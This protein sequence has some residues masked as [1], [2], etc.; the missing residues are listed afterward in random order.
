MSE[1]KFTRGPWQAWWRNGG[2]GIN[3]GSTQIAICA[4]ATDANQIT[5]EQVKA[6]AALMALAPEMH[7]TILE[8]WEMLFNGD[9]EGAYARLAAMDRKLH[10]VGLGQGD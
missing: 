7:A 9:S 10:K 5:A 8:A 6:N 1:P 3:A 4:A 2:A